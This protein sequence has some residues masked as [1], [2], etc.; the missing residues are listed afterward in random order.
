MNKFPTKT[1][2]TIK[3]GHPNQINLKKA[4]KHQGNTVDNNNKKQHSTDKNINNT[5]KTKFHIGLIKF[6]QAKF[7]SKIETFVVVFAFFLILLA[8][9]VT[10]LITTMVVTTNIEM[11]YKKNKTKKFSFL[12]GP[13]FFCHCLFGHLNVIVVE[14]RMCFE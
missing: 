4:N 3:K 9:I 2:T 8:R 10:N 11:E 13:L 6:S 14:C 5:N 12:F 1:T 7:F